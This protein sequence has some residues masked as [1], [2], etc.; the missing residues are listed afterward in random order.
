MVLMSHAEDGTQEN[1]EGLPVGGR[2]S[3]GPGNSGGRQ[4]PGEVAG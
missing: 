2:S 4:Q 3:Y 1:L